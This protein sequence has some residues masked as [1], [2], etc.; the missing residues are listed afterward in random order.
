MNKFIK[1]APHWPHSGK[2]STSSTWN[3]ILKCSVKL[4]QVC[5]TSHKSHVSGTSWHVKIAAI[6]NATPPI[7]L[8]QYTHMLLLN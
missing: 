6:D 7:T 1:H 2:D 3:S 4:T 8:G 5:E